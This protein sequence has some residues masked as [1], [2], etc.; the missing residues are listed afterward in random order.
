MS[1]EAKT[2]CFQQ[3]NGL[4]PPV[5]YNL[6]WYLVEPL[7]RKF[8]DQSHSIKVLSCTVIRRH[9]E[10]ELAALEANKAEDACKTMKA[11]VKPSRRLAEEV[12]RSCSEDTEELTNEIEE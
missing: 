11:G 7:G 4:I 2:T 5:S 6:C 12:L 3:L 9:L 1:G 8:F 10:Q